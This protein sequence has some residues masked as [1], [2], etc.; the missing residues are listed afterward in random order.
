VFYEA[1]MQKSFFSFMLSALSFL[2]E[3]KSIIIP[4]FNK[5]LRRS[6]LRHKF[7]QR[8]DL[9]SFKTQSFCGKKREYFCVVTKEHGTKKRLKFVFIYTLLN[10][11]E[12]DDDDE[13][14]DD[15]DNERQ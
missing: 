2:V 11:P 6:V 14:N 7:F 4:S 13:D 3:K 9:F 1:N 10:L 15:E 12:D 8:R 5:P